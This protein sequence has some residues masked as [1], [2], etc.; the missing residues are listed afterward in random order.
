[1]PQKER[2][3][4]KA[5]LFILISI[6][7]IFCIMIAIKGV[8]VVF[9]PLDERHVR[10]ALSDDV[11]GLRIGDDVRIGGFKVGVVKSIE[12]QGLEGTGGTPSLLVS[13]TI[14]RKYPLREDAHIGI[15][16][17][18]TGTSVLNIDD[19][20]TGAL[21]ADNTELTGHPAALSALFASLGKAGPQI[22]DILQNVKDKTIPKLN[23]AADRAGETLVSIHGASDQ[24]SGV[25]G[26][27]KPDV[28]GTMAN[29]HKITDDVKAKLPGIM[30]HVD[31]VVVTTTNTINN[32]KSTL[33]D[34]KATVANAKSISTSARIL[35][36][37]NKNKFDT[38]I[39]TFKVTLDN[40]K[41]FSADLRRSPWRLLYHPGPGEL[42]NLELYD[43]ARQFSDGAN[44]VND[45]AVA[46]RDA[47][48]NPSVDKAEIQKLI[49]RLNTSFDSFSTVEDKLWKAVKQE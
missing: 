12:L 5:G 44:G 22:N 1:M 26:D 33:E 39:G 15:Q 2:S 25:L 45:A 27:T 31:T 30:D 32:A 18:V 37:G 6:V 20:G 49:D 17:T 8:K 13:F 40:L 7:L 23:N 24:I 46:L 14:P 3:Q 42:D 47:M 11:G 36:D 9:S 29:I 38:M 43:A 35:I 10:F 19:I 28:R 41:G 48:Q 4:L 21:L 16:T 34:V